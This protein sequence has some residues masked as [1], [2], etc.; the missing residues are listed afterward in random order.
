VVEHPLR[1]LLVGQVG[2]HP[3][4]RAR[5]RLS[6]LAQPVLAPSDE[7]QPGVGVAADQA[8]YRLADAAGGSGDDGDERLLL[9]GG[10]A[11]TLWPAR[12]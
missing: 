9:V 7:H 4:R 2:R 3:G 10:H 8:G 11:R 6:Q 5:D 1:C 12:L